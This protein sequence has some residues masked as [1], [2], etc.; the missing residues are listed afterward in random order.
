MAPD[1][2]APLQEIADPANAGGGAAEGDE[3]LIMQPAPPTTTSDHQLQHDEQH[4]GQFDELEYGGDQQLVDGRLRGRPRHWSWEHFRAIGEPKVTTRRRPAQCLLCSVVI[5][6]ARPDK[7]VTHLSEVCPGAPPD[8]REGVAARHA[9]ETAARA[10]AGGGRRKRAPDG[11]LVHPR[12][13]AAMHAAL[14]HAAARQR[15][16][17]AA[18]KASLMVAAAEATGGSGGEGL[19]KE[20]QQQQQQLAQRQYYQNATPPPPPQQQ[21]SYYHHHQHQQQQHGLLPP[22]PPPQQQ[23]HYGQQQQQQGQQQQGQHSHHYGA[24]PPPPPLAGVPPSSSGGGG[25]AG[26]R[27]ARAAAVAAAAAIAN[28]NALSQSQ[29]YLSPITAGALD[30]ML[31]TWLAS[32]RVPLSSVDDP[33]FAEFMG[34]LAP[35]YQPPSKSL[36]FQVFFWGGGRV[37]FL[38]LLRPPLTFILSN[39]CPQKR[40]SFGPARA[41]AGGFAVAVRG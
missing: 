10:A 17:A 26:N 9:A 39:A 40:N 35:S 3:R 18:A 27:S 5:E 15:D 33:A 36:C 24:L 28:A 22:P 2:P 32:Q 31:L 14:A 37:F 1:V 38:F 7:F 21:P 20:Q 19:D 29:H 34:R 41:E 25:N 12:E 16:R 13:L 11:S 23:L 6:D 30:D 4:H 8:L